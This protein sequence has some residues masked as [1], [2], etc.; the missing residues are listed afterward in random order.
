MGLINQE[1]YEGLDLAEIDA[2][3]RYLADFYDV[4]QEGAEEAARSTMKANNGLKTLMA[5]YETWIPLLEDGTDGTEHSYQ[6]LRDM[7]T[8]LS[9][10]LDVS[11]EFISEDFIIEHLKEI[12]KAAQGDQ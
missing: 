3:G 11:E 8:A 6:A 1:A 5:N 4:S 9:D 7:T 2:Y 10:L 12:K